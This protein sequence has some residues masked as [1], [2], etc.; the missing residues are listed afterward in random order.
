MAALSCITL[1]HISDMQFGR[2]HRFGRLVLPE[3]DAKFGCGFAALGVL[4][5]SQCIGAMNGSQPGSSMASR[6]C[7][8]AIIRRWPAVGVG[9]AQGIAQK[10]SQRLSAKHPGL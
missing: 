3:P 4:A 5:R 7:F 8:G 1:L 10:S 9:G 2:H 6:Y